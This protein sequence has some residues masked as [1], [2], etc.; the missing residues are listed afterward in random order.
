MANIDLST[1]DLIIILVYII[2]MVWWALKHVSN[3]SSES[4]FLA[5]RNMKWP[6]V[7]FSLFA[8]GVSSSSLLGWSGEA[9][10]TGLAVFNFQWVSVLV[11]V[12]FA[13]F[14][15]P[16]YINSGVFTMPEFLEKRFDKRSKYYFSFI[17]IISN[18]FADAAVTLY[19][20]A[21]LI[22]LIYPEASIQLIVIFIAAVVALYT[23][24]GGLSSAINAELLQAIMLLFGAII[25]AFLTYNAIDNWDVFY[26]NFENTLTLHI[27]RPMDDPIVPWLGMIVGIPVLA[28]YFWGNNQ[29]LVQRILSAKSI[30][31]GRK[32]MFLAG[33]LMVLTL[34]IFIFPGVWAQYLFPG[35]ENPDQVYPKLIKELMPIG[36]IGIIIA[37]LTAA[38]AS[39][40]SAVINSAST[41]F[42]MDFYAKISG[43][44][45]TKKLVKVGQLSATVIVIIAA[46]WAPHIDQFGTLVKYYQTMVSYIAP[47]VVSVFFLGVFWKRATATGAFSGLIGGLFVAV[48]LL[49]FKDRTFMADMHFLLMVPFILG[50]SMIITI[51][52][53]LVTKPS[54]E[55]V[56]ESM[57]WKKSLFTKESMHLKGVVWYNNYRVLSIVLIAF[58]FLFALLYW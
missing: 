58:C 38:L 48:F 33:A 52:A 15:L 41:I 57:V 31:H 51:V 5:G 18:V 35:L 19:A 46:L 44:K 54:P 11:M 56:I 23:I 53:S 7:G 24:P 28:F 4:Y 32:G 14:F 20:G 30:D 16:F 2:G 50:A 1:I 3:K 36:L 22:Q 27:V 8:A 21:I 9:Y 12:F 25:L 39:S 43:E 45:D 17:T 42:T 6:V 13:W 37:S 26:Q 34:Y 55:K 49:I 10:A 47:P 40:F 29:M